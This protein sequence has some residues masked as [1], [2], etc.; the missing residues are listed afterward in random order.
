MT[1][2]FSALAALGL[3]VTLVAAAVEPA[4]AESNGGVK[5]MPLG[6]SITEGTQVPGGYRIGLWQRLASARYTVDLVGSQYNG[7]GSLGDHDHEGHPGWRIDQVAANVAGWLG[8]YQPRTVLLHIGTNDV[9]QNYDLGNAPNRL[10][11]L[12]DRVTN[13]APG[14]DVFVAQIIP[15]ANSG[16][17]NAVR[18]FNAAVPG[19]VQGK[20]NAGKRVH[21]VDMHAALATADLIDGVHPTAGGYD[22]M[23]AVWYAALSSVPGSIGSPGAQAGATIVGAQSGRCV[24]VPGSSTAN[25]V[26]VQLWD[27]HGGA[28]QR[29]TYTSDRRLTGNGGKCLDAAGSAN[30]AAVVLWDCNGQANQRW[31]LNADGSVTGLASGLCLDVSGAATANGSKIQLWGCWGGANQRWSIRA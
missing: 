17:E 23:A 31:S 7:P 5:V 9:L 8:T 30:G 15:L 14:A 10:S 22:K 6:D 29:W 1:R 2:F 25:G 24:D 13:A 28:N 20:V 21:L 18:A 26:Q 27:C 4:S 16:Q 11:A 3:A 19:I 12:I